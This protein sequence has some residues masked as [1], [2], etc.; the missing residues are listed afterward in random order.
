MNVN[1]HAVDDGGIRK[2]SDISFLNKCQ[3]KLPFVVSCM[4]VDIYKKLNT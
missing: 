4:L 1:F 2:R 3:E